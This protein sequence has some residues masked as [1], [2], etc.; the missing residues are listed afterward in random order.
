MSE[1]IDEKSSKAKGKRVSTL[2]IASIEDITPE[3]EHDPEEEEEGET[4]IATETEEP[5]T[6][7]ADD[8]EKKTEREQP[9][10]LEVEGVTMTFEKPTD[11]QLDLF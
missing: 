2:E 4:D 7:T 8:T 3:P 11:T 1:F 9:E 5:G 10:S 6:D